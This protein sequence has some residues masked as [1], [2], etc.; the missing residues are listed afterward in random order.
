MCYFSI[1]TQAT[2]NNNKTKK[3]K[4][5]KLLLKALTFLVSHACLERFLS[6]SDVVSSIPGTVNS[7]TGERTGGRRTIREG[8]S[9]QLHGSTDRARL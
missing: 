1:F 7:K 4:R 3:K 9:L 2:L 6:V 8:I 5:R